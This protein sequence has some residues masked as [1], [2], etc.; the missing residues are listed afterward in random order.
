MKSFGISAL[1][2]YEGEQIKE[3]EM[4]GAFSMH[5]KMKNA[6]NILARTS[7]EIT[8]LRIPRRR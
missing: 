2:Y 3:D 1:Q 4:G 8:P 5:E 6:N 7:E